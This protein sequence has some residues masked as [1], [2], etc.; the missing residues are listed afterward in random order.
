MVTYARTRAGFCYG[1]ERSFTVADGRNEAVVE[2]NTMS[3]QRK[4]Y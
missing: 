3:C 2:R 4:R 1:Q